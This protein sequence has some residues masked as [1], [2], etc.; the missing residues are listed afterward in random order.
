MGAKALPAASS[1]KRE[2]LEKAS[3]ASTGSGSMLANFCCAKALGTAAD[4]RSAMLATIRF[5]NMLCVI[6]RLAPKDVA[7][8]FEIPHP[9]HDDHASRI[10]P[11]TCTQT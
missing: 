6:T 8:V 3:M 11:S 9:S 2:E 7:E 4:S 10:S 5:H 1:L